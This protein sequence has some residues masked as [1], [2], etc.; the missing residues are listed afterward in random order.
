MPSSRRT[1]S[2]KSVSQSAQS[3][4]L[5]W[6]APQFHFFPKSSLWTIVALAL[7]ITASYGFFLV[8]FF[9]LAAIVLLGG[10]TL[11]LMANA[12]PKIYEHKVDRKGIW[13]GKNL[14][15]WVTLRSFWTVPHEGYDKLYLETTDRI[16]PQKTLLFPRAKHLS[17]REAVGRH[18]PEHP[19]RGELFSETLA[20]LLRI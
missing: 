8:N 19:T 18:I 13:V 6:R 3:S 10:L 20:R 9:A 12:R 1:K 7:T 17:I 16:R 2:A 14:I 11:I 15:H 5:S 4:A